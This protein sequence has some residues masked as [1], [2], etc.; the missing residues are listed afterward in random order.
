MRLLFI[1]PEPPYP[2]A[3]G[4]SLL[5]YHHIRE[6]SRKHTIDLVSFVPGKA[7]F[8]TT[9]LQ[10]FC[11]EIV[12][13]PHSRPQQLASLIRGAVD[14]RP[15]QVALYDS[16][17][18]RK[19][20]RTLR[21]RHAYDAVICVLSRTAQYGRDA[22][23]MSRTIL[24]MVD[25]LALNYSRSLAWRPLRLQ[26]LFREEARRLREYESSIM[27]SF[28]C[29]LLTCEADAAEYGHLMGAPSAFGWVPHVVDREWLVKG[30]GQ[31]AG[32]NTRK[33]GA[34]VMTGNMF[35]APNR[36]AA[37]YFAE[38]I[39][40]LIRELYPPANL[41]L[42]GSRPG[43]TLR[44]LAKRPGITVT[45]SVPDIRPYLHCARVAICPVRL[46]VG[47][48][49]KVLEAMA[50]GLPVVTTSAGNRGVKGVSGVH[51]IV[52]DEPPSFANAVISLL[53]GERWNEIANAARSFVERN[54]APSRSAEKLASYAIGSDGEVPAV[55]PRSLSRQQR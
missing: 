47:T 21:D 12:L 54:H 44:K 16:A 17:E 50:C 52:A 30:H 38:E 28:D 26:P 43:A 34:I 18:A 32:W 41:S 7:V 24:N 22:G 29:T 14:G 40:P 3:R 19:V 39:F 27:G 11:D 2:P 36:D 15:L 55:P 9:H 31:D 1:T 42:V 10:E 6:L 49:T 33:E 20:V 53:R 5:T 46:D 45:G 25:P 51:L 13:V 23:P 8:Q 4:Y 48:Q 35:Y 37:L